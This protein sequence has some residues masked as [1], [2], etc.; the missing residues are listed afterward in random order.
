MKT[1]R[2]QG[3]GGLTFGGE[4]LNCGHAQCSGAC[5]VCY[6]CRPIIS[7]IEVRS[8]AS[9]ESLTARLRELLDRMEA[10]TNEAQLLLDEIECES[11]LVGEDGKRVDEE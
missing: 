5:E 7:K 2:K 10:L 9:L 4:C 6:V 11:G 1:P 8:T 3:S